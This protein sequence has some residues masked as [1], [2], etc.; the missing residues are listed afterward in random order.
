MITIYRHPDCERCAR[1]AAAHKRFDWLNRV[2]TSTET[3]PN[4]PL[5]KGAICVV[6]EKTGQCYLGVDAV[7]RIARDIPLYSL[8][9]PLLYIPALARY[10][11]QDAR[12]CSNSCEV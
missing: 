8:L 4:G 9:L 12:G 3:P 6:D 1:Y 5:V 2:Q 10:A 11:D 7:R